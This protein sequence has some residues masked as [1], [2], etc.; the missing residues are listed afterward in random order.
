[1]VPYIIH[2]NIVINK[3]HNFDLFIQNENKIAKVIFNY[4][5][6]SHYKKVHIEHGYIFNKTITIVQMAKSP[7][8]VI[9]CTSITIPAQIYTVLMH[10]D[11][12]DD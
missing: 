2:H 4:Q 10:I 9:T 6:L 8:I 3:V 7:N 1:M 11:N 12:C 5:I